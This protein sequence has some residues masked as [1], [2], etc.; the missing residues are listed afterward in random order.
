MRLLVVALLAL[1]AG[2]LAAG[3]G[4]A[5][6][7][8][9]VTALD[10]PTPV[11]VVPSPTLAVPSPTTAPTATATATTAPS[12][13]PS[14][15]PLPES[16]EQPPGEASPPTPAVTPS[17]IP[18][19]TPCAQPGRV[20]QGT[21]ESAVAGEPMRYR[22]YLP[23]CYGVDDR[24]Y[25]TLYMFGGNIH[26]D[27]IWDNLG[28]DEAAE[29]MITRG[30]IPPLL[31]VM[32]D[33]GWLANTT[34]S[35][36]NSYEGFVL[37]ELIPHIEATYRARA[38]ADG[39]AV[40]GLSRGGY[41]SLM[42]AFRRPDLFQSVGA[43][44]PALIDSHAGPAEDPRVTG[45]T[46]DLGDLRIWV[47]IGE[48]DPYLIEALPLHEALTAAGVAHEWRVEPGTHEEAFWRARLEQYLMWY[49]G[50]WRVASGG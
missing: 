26:D 1:L 25:P 44:S 19:P 8:P 23:P 22:V 49:S 28:L 38:E 2:L 3:C 24:F 47:D 33:N 9:A 27:A 13:S 15:S 32:P 29:A 34:T 5:A 4:A 37:N 36:P 31:I 39:R 6:R 12:P 50:G 30:D 48:R 17:V 40:G 42:M 45:T 46:N 7:S 11:I 21:L 10:P 20:E 18:L 14:A 41:W 43:H 35:G 16:E